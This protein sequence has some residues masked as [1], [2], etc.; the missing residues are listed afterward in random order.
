MGRVTSRVGLAMGVALACAA[1]GCGSAREVRAYA[2]AKQDDR[3][4]S[5]VGMIGDSGISLDDRVN[6]MRVLV[7][8]G[9]P[10]VIPSLV[11]ASDDPR[12]CEAALGV[13][14]DD[15]SDSGRTP[16]VGDVCRRLLRGW[17]GERDVRDWKAWWIAYRDG[18]PLPVPPA[19][20]REGARY[21][22]AAR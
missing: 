14:P 12:A 10:D 9:R 21:A 15:P 11:T 3:Y 1:V 18:A 7:Q 20:P 4:T 5:L 19:T 16:T 2:D 6:A 17:F 8:C 13:L 22:S